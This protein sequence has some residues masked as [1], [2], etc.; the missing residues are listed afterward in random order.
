MFRLDIL[1]RVVVAACVIVLLSIVVTRNAA[2]QT[3]SPLNGP[4]IAKNVKGIS[5]DNSATPIVYTAD[6]TYTLKSTNGGIAW[7]ATPTAI[8]APLV[9]LCKP[10]ANALVTT[11]GI[12]FFKKSTDGGSSWADFTAP[13]TSNLTPLRLSGSPITTTEMYL[14]RNWDATNISVY[15]STNSGLTWGQSTN[16]TFHTD[17]YDVAPYPISGVGRDQ[18]VWA[19]GTAPAGQTDK[20]LWYSPDAGETWQFVSGTSGYDLKSVAVI[21][22]TSNPHLY[23]AKSNGD[24]F[25]STNLGISWSGVL[26][27][28]FLANTIRTN[29]SNNYIYV[30]TQNGMYRSTDEGGAWNS[31]NSGL[32]NDLVVQSLA[33][34]TSGTLFAGTVGSMYKSTDNGSTWKNVG[35]MN[36]SSVVSNG[37]NT[38]AVAKDNGYVG[39][40]A[41][42]A[43]TNSYVSSAGADFSSEQVYRNPHNSNIFVSGAL[44]GTA[45]LYRSTDGGTNFSLITTPVTSGGK[46][47]GAIAHPTVTSQMY[48]FGGGTVGTSWKSLFSS[49]DGGV[50]WNATSPDWDAT[51]IYV[52]DLA[53]LNNGTARLFAALSNGKVYKSDDNGASWGEVLT[54]GAGNI[55]YSVA[56]NPNQPSVVYVASS[57]G[58][59]KS[60]NSGASGLWSNMGGGSSKRVILMAP[61]TSTAVNHVITLSTDGTTIKY[62]FA[63]G[64]NWNVGTG[65]LPTPINDIRSE[66]SSDNVIYAATVGGVF[67]IAKP[68]TSPTLL[69]PVSQSLQDVNVPLTWQS[70][71][72]ATYHVMVDDDAG[73]SSPNVDLL[74][75]SG[76]SFTNYNLTVAPPPLDPED[77]Y[78]PMRYYWKVAAS[79]LAGESSFPAAFDFQTQTTGTITLYVSGGVGQHPQLSWTS[80]DGDNGSVYTIFRYSC[81][82]PGPDCA[83]EPYPLLAQTTGTSYTDNGVT[84]VSKTVANVQYYYQVRRSAISNKGA[85]FANQQQRAVPNPVSDESLP[86]E[87]KLGHNYPNPFNPVTEIRYALSE[88]THVKLLVYDVLGRVIATLVDESQSGGYKSVHFDAASLPSGMY[89]YRLSA[90]AFT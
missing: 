6:N 41:S 64:S 3:W 45:K 31:I 50:T 69:S 60:T 79:N 1:S 56:V 11:G 59:F 86:T 29:S 53:A 24:I 36:V 20:G 13:L 37:T 52:N 78:M 67:R 82:Y 27:T 4:Q 75:L 42:S 58:L 15:K 72:N 5:A 28:G 88:D 84:I 57:V 90:G 87:T 77:P 43:W 7:R 55:A 89:Y 70:V 85:V 51:G 12:N 32:G 10:D 39:K 80:A 76:T 35:V 40:Y 62:S 16:F 26:S 83:V 81:P 54:V 8:S 22:K 71:S 9:I 73:F 65:N 17:V 38:W 47:N 30:A 49:A 61:G 74:N 21:H 46:Y 66:A 25:K 63:G 34:N 23:V 19:A 44:S 33:I 68:G 48:L 14:G 18:W 2:T